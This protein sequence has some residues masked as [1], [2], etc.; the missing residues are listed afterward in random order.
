MGNEASLEGGEGPLSGLPEGLVP[1]GKGG[2]VR[3]PGGTEADL[4]Q[5]SEEDRRQL[6]A[7]MS[8]AQ[9]RQ[10]GGAAAARRQGSLYSIC[11]SNLQH[12]TRIVIH[13]RGVSGR[14]LTV[15]LQVV[16]TAS[17]GKHKTQK[18]QSSSSR[19]FIILPSAPR[20]YPIPGARIKGLLLTSAA[21]NG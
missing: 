14:A 10:S 2:F 12:T 13:E 19:P 5:L 9:S 3:L 21:L 6:T 1:D 7:A 15:C 16:C 4:S 20:N 17:F 18:R 11:L 8:R